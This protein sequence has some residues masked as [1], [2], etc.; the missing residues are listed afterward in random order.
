[1][2]IFKLN[3]MLKNLLFIALVSFTFSCSPED[4]SNENERTNNEV[5]EEETDPNA[6]EEPETE[7]SDSDTDSDSEN[8]DTN[9]DDDNEEE[10]EDTEGDQTD[11]STPPSAN[12]DLSYWNLSIPIEEA[13]GT[14]TDIT[15]SELIN[16]YENSSYFYTGSDGAMVF[17]NFITG[18]KTSV[19]TKYTRSEL[20]EMIYGVRYDNV[21]GLSTK[22]IANNWV[23]G[24]SDSAIQ[25]QAGAVDGELTAT[26]AVNHVTS[27]GDSGQ[28]GR[29]IIGQIHA[30]S[31]E[32]CR[33]YYRK[34]PNNTKGSIYFAHEPTE[35]TGISEQWHEM[36]GSDSSSASDPVDGIAL[37]EKF[38]YSIKVI[39]NTLTV[40]IIREGKDDVVKTIDM[41]NSGFA[42]DYMYFKAGVYT[43]NNSGD[44]TDYDEVSF[45]NLN[46]T[47]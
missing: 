30:S 31:D 24:N 23:F 32:P 42:N 2:K 36:I 26:V 11:S 16:G 38:S 40:T 7:E 34:L 17:K 22:D 46:I 45:Y 13:N 12:F 6:E 29:V 44:P 37:N 10:T 28:V 33:L 21:S 35:E 14:A 4:V 47:H 1:M 19:N 41:T 5:S 20:R 39:G 9:D 27:T 43:Q 8:E 15:T 25:S 3:N 18:A